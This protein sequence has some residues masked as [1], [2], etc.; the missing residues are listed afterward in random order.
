M[1]L[2][3]SDKRADD[4]IVKLADM[5]EDGISN[6]NEVVRFTPSVKIGRRYLALKHRGYSYSIQVDVAKLH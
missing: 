3:H 4:L 6:G 1:N 2:D 5:F